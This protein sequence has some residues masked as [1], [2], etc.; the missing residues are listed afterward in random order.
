MF[1]NLWTVYVNADFF[2]VRA[3]IPPGGKIEQ[4]GLPGAR[5][6]GRVLESLFSEELPLKSVFCPLDCVKGQF[7]S[8]A[9]P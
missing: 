9:V 3:V 5:N 2:V 1:Y 6:N 8:R 7:Q 4:P